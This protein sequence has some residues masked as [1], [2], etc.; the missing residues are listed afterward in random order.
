[1]A[2]HGQAGEN[3]WTEAVALKPSHDYQTFGD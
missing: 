1:M 3:E 2:T